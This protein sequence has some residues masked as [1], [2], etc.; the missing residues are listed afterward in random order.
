MA[1]CSNQ[2]ICYGSCTGG[3]STTCSGSCT[4]GCS[5]TCSGTC[6]GGCS[7]CAG[8]GTCSGSCSNCA[9]AGTCSG[10]CS[11]SCQ[12]KCT[13]KCLGACNSGCSSEANL[14][15]YAA[16]SLQ[17]KFMNSDMTNIK[18]VITAAAARK[19]SPQSLPGLGFGVQIDDGNMT[20]IKTA[21]TNLGFTPSVT[22]TAGYSATKAQGQ[23]IINKAKQ[24]YEHIYPKD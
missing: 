15:A 6:S 17:E 9:G 1:N 5:T 8:A 19:G 10:G 2:S 20:S 24:A 22:F 16:L 11:G 18:N 13:K 4:G 23:E 12:G 21:L 14:S 3:C 7:S